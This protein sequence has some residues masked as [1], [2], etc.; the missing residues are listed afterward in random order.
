MK[1]FGVHSC[2]AIITA[3]IKKMFAR[4]LQQTESSNV[5][6][7]ESVILEEG[8]QYVVKYWYAIC[9][10][11][12]NSPA[13]RSGTDLHYHVRNARLQWQQ[14]MLKKFQTLMS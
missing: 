9:F 12:T 3:H 1:N 11:K 7:S 14:T 2:T 8:V 6:S 13:R 4:V 10:Q 5:N